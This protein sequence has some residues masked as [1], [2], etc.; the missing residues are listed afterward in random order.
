V[1][2]HL[3]LMLVVLVVLIGALV[4]DVSL[5]HVP[6]PWISLSSFDA[7]VLQM[8]QAYTPLEVLGGAAHPVVAI[9]LGCGFILVIFVLTIVARILGAI[10]GLASLRLVRFLVAGRGGVAK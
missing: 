5:A 10:L 9:P 1:K 7:A 6:G 2:R 3:Q 4:V 8:I